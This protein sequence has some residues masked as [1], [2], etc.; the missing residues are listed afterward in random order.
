MQLRCQTSQGAVCTSD[1][2]GCQCC[3]CVCFQ[4]HKSLRELK[5]SLGWCHTI[6][7]QARSSILDMW[8]DITSILSLSCSNSRACLLL[9]R[10]F[11]YG[12]NL[13]PI[14]LAWWKS[15]PCPCP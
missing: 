11:I 5:L 7:Q 9:W 2:S 13:E 15:W 4:N 3:C 1:W 12:R 8:Q 14:H 10:C 6:L